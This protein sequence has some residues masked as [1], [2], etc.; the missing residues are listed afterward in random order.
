MK[1][2]KT[3]DG[4][5]YERA[6]LVTARNLREVREVLRSHTGQELALAVQYA[7]GAKATPETLEQL[8]EIANPEPF[9]IESIQVKTARGTD[10]SI[11]VRFGGKPGAKGT[12]SYRVSGNK[13]EVFAV[14]TKL[15]IIVKECFPWYSELASMSVLRAV[16]AFGYGL[17]VAAVAIILI[18]GLAVHQWSYGAP[19]LA[20]AILLVFAAPIL[21]AMFPRCLFAFGDGELQEAK[22][23]RRR[24]VFSRGVLY[25]V[26]LAIFGGIFAAYQLRDLVVTK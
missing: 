17:A 3:E 11:W 2:V 14:V 19:L 21:R 10:P 18:R 24:K 9:P 1:A 7:D 4:R 6:I 23:A 12:A 25:A 15:D 16:A 22:Y 5:E 8:L 13:D 26:L 20:L